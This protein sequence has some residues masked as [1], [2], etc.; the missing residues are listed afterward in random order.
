MGAACTDGSYFQVRWRDIWPTLQLIDIFFGEM[1]A[2]VAFA[3][4]RATS[5]TGKKRCTFDRPDVSALI[6]APSLLLLARACVH[7]GQRAR[8]CSFALQRGA[9]GIL[10]I[11]ARLGAVRNEGEI[12][13]L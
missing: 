5:W 10:Q 2:I 11:F 3:A 13:G 1:L 8:R 12:V 4:A 6:R 7:G 9:V